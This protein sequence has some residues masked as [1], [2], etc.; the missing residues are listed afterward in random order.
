MFCKSYGQLSFY[1]SPKKSLAHTNKRRRT[2]V[3]VTVHMNCTFPA[4]LQ[5][6][7]AEESWAA[8]RFHF[9]AKIHTSLKSGHFPSKS[10]LIPNFL[11]CFKFK[12][13]RK[14]P[15]GHLD[16]RRKSSFALGAVHILRNTNLSP[17]HITHISC[18]ILFIL[19][20]EKQ[21]RSWNFHYL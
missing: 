17:G 21:N 5:Q 3:I 15:S 18:D 19:G 16:P 20:P 12:Y 10:Q 6:K 7:L 13:M 1:P 2:Y 8:F 11:M 14:S 4:V 9:E